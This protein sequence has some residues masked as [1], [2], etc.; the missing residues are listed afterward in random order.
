MQNPTK[1]VLLGY[2]IEH[3]H[4]LKNWVK[5]LSSIVFR[6]DKDD[7]M[8]YELD[9]IKVEF[10]GYESKPSHYELLIRMAKG[11]KRF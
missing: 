7:V 10:I 2:V 5:I 8:M 4:F 1:G 9:N 6:I 3:Q 11:V